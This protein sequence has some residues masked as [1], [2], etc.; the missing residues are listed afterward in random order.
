MYLDY[1]KLAL[2]ANGIPETPTLVLQT[3]SGET[4]GVIPGV[5]N[6]KMNIKFSEP[7]E[8]TFDVP[9]VIDGHPNWVYDELTGY[10]RIYTEHYGVYVVM[11]PAKDADGISDI[12]SIRAYSI[13]KSLEA[14]KF[15]LEEGT[16]KF[17]DSTNPK[18]GSTIFGRILEIAIGWNAG[19]ISP[20]IAQRYRTFTQYDDYLLSFI[21]N[22]APDKYRCVFV[23]DPYQKTINVYD[24]DEERS[25]LPIYLDFDNLLESVGIEELSDELVTAIRPY[26]ADGLDVREVNPIGTNWIYDLSYFVANG[27]IPSA[28]AEK[29]D[30]WQKKVQQSRQRFEGLSAFRASSTAKLLAAKASLVDLQGELET[31]ISQQSVT[32]QALANEITEQGKKTQQQVLDDINAKIAAKKQEISNQESVISNINNELDS[33]NSAISTITEELGISNYFSDAEYETLAHY[34]IEQDITE[35]TFVASDIDESLSGNSYVLTN[36]TVKVSGSSI[37]EVD[38]TADFKKKMYSLS[39]GTFS[40]SGASPVSGD[41]VRGT[42]ELTTSGSFVLSLYAGSIKVNDSTASSGMITMSGELSNFTSDI[43]QKTVDGITTLEGTSMQFY[44]ASGSMYLT[45][46]INDYKRYSVKMELYEHGVGILD[47]LATP[48]YEFSVESGNFLFA[49]EFA[50][51]RNKLELA[52][53]LSPLTSSNLKL[54]LRIKTSS[55]SFSQIGLSVTMLSIR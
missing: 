10:R 45:A 9:A 49:K 51:F 4:M 38:L 37:S 42:L 25:T 39:G 1:S 52:S 30:G 48:T 13:E 28:L 34:L 26:G 16:Y 29:Y 47:D 3:L 18:N 8:M 36:Q 11:N 6:L 14:K 21:Y 35:D 41:V 22:A 5:S 46:N 20:T 7:S 33:V 12:K 55:P 17:Y 43:S 32:I 44:T 54:T 40:F 23:F 24:A 31:L 2:D 19:Y 50:P 27:D 53:R 15:F